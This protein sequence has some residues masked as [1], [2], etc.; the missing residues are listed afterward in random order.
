MTSREGEHVESTNPSKDEV[1][2]GYNFLLDKIDELLNLEEEEQFINNIDI[3]ILNDNNISPW[4]DN[5]NIETIE[6]RGLNVEQ[7]DVNDEQEVKDALFSTA[8]VL[9]Q[10][11]NVIVDT[12]SK[13]CIIAKQFLDR[14]NKDI[15]AAS[16]IQVVDIMGNKSIPLGKVLNVPVRIGKY[17]ILIDMLVTNSKEYNVVLGNEYLDKVKATIDFASGIMTIGWNEDYESV[18]ITCWEKVNDPKTFVHISYKPQLQFK[19]D[20]ELEDE[21]ENLENV[22]CYSM[23]IKVDNTF[24][25]QNS[26]IIPTIRIE[27]NR[28]G[29][30]MDETFK[31]IKPEVEEIIKEKQKDEYKGQLTPINEAKSTYLGVYLKDQQKELITQLLKE[32]QDIFA[33][34]F[35]ELRQTNVVTHS[36]NTSNHLPI[37]QR[38]YRA[39]PKEQEHIKK[40]IESMEKEGIIR[41]SKSPWSSPVVLVVKKNGKLRFCVD[42]RKLNNHTK[43]DTYPLPR[44]DEMLDALG[45]AK[46]FTS[47]DLT[48]GY[49]QVQVKEE[50]KEKTAFITKFGLYEFNVMPFGL[51]NAPA[52][53]QRLMEKVLQPVLW[54]KAMVY[55][56]D[57]N[58]YSETFEQHIEDLKEVFKL[59]K[60][61]NLRINPEKCH[62]GTNQMQFLGHVIGCDGIKPDP[63]KVDKL[64]NLIPPRNITELRAF[65]GLA[66]YYRRF[67]ENF[68]KKAAPLFKLLQK[69]V[70]FIWTDKHQQVFD[71]L[72][73]RLTTAPILQYPDYNQPFLLFTDASY[74]GLGA[75]L[76]QVREGKEHVIAYASRTLSPAEKNYS[77]V[78]LECLASVWAV[79]YFR[80]YI[81]GS[82]F[83]L[84]T[85]H[86]ALQW[87]LNNTTLNENK[88]ITRWRLTLQEYQY[89]IKYR[90]GKRNQ[91]AD[92]FS[93]LPTTDPIDN[94]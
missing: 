14:M 47:L 38:A 90:A 78:E 9:N 41:P 11:I 71:W 61:A 81:H 68:S 22:R 23:N 18:P 24:T 44:I 16:N 8:E 5:N 57:V 64:N 32:N 27:H 46:W 28:K 65:L 77:T 74:L 87:L 33:T 30:Q 1:E 10:E 82:R 31:M 55:I 45:K 69:D 54:K 56:D 93:R 94:G 72:K 48:S 40:E 17:E 51:C 39:S 50:D 42:Y 36:I 89:D 79:K 80:H 2:D 20:L 76:S 12:G 73:Y 7:Q 35:S 52:T 84:I 66:S 59:I 49:W 91:N 75:V 15:D 88:R 34:Q 6:I 70:L 29:T 25:Q 3:N 60:D 19:Q 13:G 92:F 43:K 58:I 21:D 85:D 53:F 67:I 37:K 63:Q 4:L 83:T 62:F 86:K 26:Q